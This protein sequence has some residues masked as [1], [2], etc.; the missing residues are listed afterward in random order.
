MVI[1]QDAMELPKVHKQGFPLRIVV[2]S[3]ETFHWKVLCMTWQ[4]YYMKL[5]IILSKDRHQTSKTVGRL[6]KISIRKILNRMKY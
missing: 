6:S 4:D 2:S 3:V 5:L 1:Y